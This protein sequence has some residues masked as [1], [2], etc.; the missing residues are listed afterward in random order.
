MFVFLQYQL[1]NFA[2][3]T[4]SMIF[5]LI[6]DEKIRACL[7]KLLSRAGLILDKP[8]PHSTFEINHSGQEGT[9]KRKSSID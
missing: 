8:I 9:D 1:D 4:Y 5:W 3:M 6:A 2:G 7:Q